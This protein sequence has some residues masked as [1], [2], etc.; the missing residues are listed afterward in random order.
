[1]NLF[2]ICQSEGGWGGGAAELL[3][4][5]MDHIIHIAAKWHLIVHGSNDPVNF[6]NLALFSQLGWGG[7]GVSLPHRKDRVERYLSKW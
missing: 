2:D 6:G 3:S 1:M 5:T 7:G 4:K